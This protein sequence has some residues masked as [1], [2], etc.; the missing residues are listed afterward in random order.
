MENFMDIVRSPSSDD[1]MDVSVASNDAMD[2]EYP[3]MNNM[4]VAQEPTKEFDIDFVGSDYDENTGNI[5]AYFRDLSKARSEKNKQVFKLNKRSID[6]KQLAK[7]VEIANDSTE[8]L[9]HIYYNISNAYYHDLKDLERRYNLHGLAVVN[10]DKLRTESRIFVF[11]T[12]YMIII[13]KLLNTILDDRM[14]KEKTHSEKIRSWINHLSVIAAGA[15]GRTLKAGIS[16]VDDFFAIKYPIRK[17]EDL[18][19]EY[20]VGSRIN[21]LRD[22]GICLGFVYTYTEFFSTKAIV[23]QKEKKNYDFVSWAVDDNAFPIRYLALENIAN[24]EVMEDYIIKRDLNIYHSMSLFYNIFL[25]LSAAN[26]ELKYTHWDLHPGNV[27]M[28]PQREDAWTLI[29]LGTRTYYVKTFGYL[30]FI[31]DHGFASVDINGTVIGPDPTSEAGQNTNFRGFPLFLQDIYSILISWFAYLSSQNPKTENSNKFIEILRRLMPYFFLN[32]KDSYN[33][34]LNKFNYYILQ[35]PNRRNLSPAENNKYREIQQYLIYYR[36]PRSYSDNSPKDFLAEFHTHILSVY[37]DYK[38]SEILINDKEKVKK[39]RVVLSCNDFR[40][41]PRLEIEDNL[42]KAPEDMRDLC[43][44]GTNINTLSNNTQNKIIMQFNNNIK[45]ISNRIKLNTDR[46]HEFVSLNHIYLIRNTDYK[47]FLLN[48]PNF[49]LDLQ[50]FYV[51][52]VNIWHSYYD[53]VNNYHNLMCVSPNGVLEN[54]KNRL[55]TKLSH[56]SAVRSGLFAYGIN[57]WDELRLRYGN[58]GN[59]LKHIRGSDFY[60]ENLAVVLYIIEHDINI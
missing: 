49:Y 15:F 55:Y 56:F 58:D 9:R 21:T 11:N 46:A 4:S 16:V 26:E 28:S 45:N 6:K 40:C 37:P 44:L 19:H 60:T 29:K 43:Y 35:I 59:F 30:P 24:S 1:A 2:V 3:S 54:E 36:L 39:D 41:K 22:N 13:H 12:Q 10:Y 8:T 38:I 33:E 25:N 42:L 7:Y 5:T 23:V 47:I 34:I 48:F 31:I 32:G 27:L 17:G 51:T 50:K 52:L 53:L 20:I 57:I 14:A 18:R